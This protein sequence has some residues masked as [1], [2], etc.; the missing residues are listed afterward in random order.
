VQRSEIVGER[1]TLH[2]ST[3]D[4]TARALVGSAIPW[5]DLEVKSTDLEETFIKLVHNG[6]GAEA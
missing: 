1:V 5:R 3:P 6:K 2:T 4:A